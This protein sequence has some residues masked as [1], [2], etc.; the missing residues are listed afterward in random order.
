LSLLRG[1]ELKLDIGY[2]DIDPLRQYYLSE[3]HIAAQVA[4]QS[5]IRQLAGR[6]ITSRL[7]SRLPVLKYVPPK[8]VKREKHFHYS[9]DVFNFPDNSYIEGYWQSEK[10]FIGHRD[11]L[12]TELTL[13]C[14]PD[15][16]CL[17]FRSR[18]EEVNSV[19]IHVRRG[20]YV[21]NPHTN[22]IHGSCPVEYYRA[23]VELLTRTVP[24][25][26]FFVFSDDP[27]WARYAFQ[28]L[29]R[30]PLQFTA[31]GRPA[32]IDMHLMSR[33]RHNIIAN[34]TYSWWAA[35]L[36]RNP[37]KIVIAPRKWFQVDDF[38]T[39]DLFPEGWIRI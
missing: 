27:A 30:H 14:E 29:T 22:R 13:K 38:D 6:K 28:G 7:R 8:R 15:V 20:D 16:E 18:L 24:E 31:A 17:R 33:C 35:W 9:P 3:Y 19:S 4:T 32:P 34:S 36:N 10:Y 21:G 23:A 26:I 11:L 1:R 5:E 39:K 37:D 12:L 25:P 2:F